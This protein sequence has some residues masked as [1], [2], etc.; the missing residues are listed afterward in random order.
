[1]GFKFELKFE[2]KCK[3]KLKLKLKFFECLGRE[4][5]SLI[6]KGDS[7]EYASIVS[8]P[9]HSYPKHRDFAADPRFRPG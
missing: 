2:L 7:V 9:V 6:Q 3:L 5:L 8:R 4:G 1:M